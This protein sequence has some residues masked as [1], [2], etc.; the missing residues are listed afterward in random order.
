MAYVFFYLSAAVL[1]IIFLICCKFNKPKLPNIIIGLTTVGYSLIF[2]IL[3]GDQLKLFYYI[4]LQ[5]STSYMI[6]SA[7]LI[8][9]FLNVVYTMFLPKN[10]TNVL[11][12]TSGWIIALLFFEYA[13]LLTKTI[14]FTGWKPFPWSIVIYIVEY[15]WIYFFYRFLTKKY[16]P[17][18]LEFS[19]QDS[20]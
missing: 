2:D 12:Y 6:L 19:S 16:L 8:Y 15:I 3:F 1:L 20:E 11:V 9:S 14:V 18:V 10:N 13:S 7:V 17:V 5:V 4:N